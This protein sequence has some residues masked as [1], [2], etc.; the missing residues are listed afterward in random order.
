M[1]LQDTPR[2]QNFWGM[3][4][5]SYTLGQHFRAKWGNKLPHRCQ[6]VTPWVNIVG[7]MELQNTPIGTTLWCQWGYKISPLGQHFWA[8][9]GNKLPHRCQQIPP[10]STFR[11]KG[12]AIYPS[13]T[14]ICPQGQHA[15]DYRVTR[16]PPGSTF[17]TKGAASHPG[18]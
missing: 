14:T 3:R 11:T 6:Q 7:P 5:A 18:S 15:G 4:A 8:K 12:A 10:G 13:T 9:W 17:R 16:T 1:G 2:G